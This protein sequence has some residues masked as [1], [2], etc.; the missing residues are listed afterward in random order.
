MRKSEGEMGHR[1]A[2]YSPRWGQNSWPRMAMLCSFNQ[3]ADK[4]NIGRVRTLDNSSPI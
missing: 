4:M 1:S 3:T 2:T